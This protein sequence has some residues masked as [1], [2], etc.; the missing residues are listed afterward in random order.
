MLYYENI[1]AKWIANYCLFVSVC[2]LTAILN[3]MFFDNPQKLMQ[4][5]ILAGALIFEVKNYLIIKL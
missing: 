4:T 2:F 3:I 5:D 1:Y